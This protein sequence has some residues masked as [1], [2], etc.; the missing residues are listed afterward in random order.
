[1]VMNLDDYDKKSSRWI[2][3]S[4]RIT[5]VG[6]TTFAAAYRNG[7]VKIH[8]LFSGNVLSEISNHEQE[9]DGVY[10]LTAHKN[11]RLACVASQ[12]ATIWDIS[13]PHEPELIKKF[14]TGRD[15]T[16]AK[17]LDPE[18]IIVALDS[19]Y[20]ACVN[21]VKSSRIFPR[22]R[23]VWRTKISDGQQV[24]DI[25][26][27]DNT[28]LASSRRG[29]LTI[30]CRETGSII[31]KL[32][33]SK[34]YD[35]NCVYELEPGKILAINDNSEW[36]IWNTESGEKLREE[37]MS[38][39]LLVLRIC[40]FSTGKIALAGYRKREVVKGKI[41][42]DAMVVMIANLDTEYAGAF[43]SNNVKEI[44]QAIK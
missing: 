22:R 16:Y 40:K 36:Q 2:Y 11:G 24:L 31:R 21:L 34:F 35:V 32:Q 44:R 4:Q 41:I 1:M 12:T 23:D 30:L 3:N 15:V 8:D 26:I 33:S 9:P 37:S 10:G 28:V 13:S 17:F 18:H 5:N 42:P 20:V 39:R 7:K 14:K 27:T 6:P 29:G 43:I 25:Q 38:D 19:G